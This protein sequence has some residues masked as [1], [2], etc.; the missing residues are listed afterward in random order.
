MGTSSKLLVVFG[1]VLVGMF[2]AA[3]A[4]ADIIPQ[5]SSVTPDGPN[6]LWTYDVKITTAEEV[7]THAGTPTSTYGNYVTIY[8]V[9]G[10]V[11]GS[12]SQ[13]AGWTASDQATG[14][15]PQLEAP[16]AATWLVG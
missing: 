9:A 14:V 4:R 6:F 5:L 1:A 8:D 15:T 2:V 12:E 11:S 10:L 16:G 13:P 7:D 3:S